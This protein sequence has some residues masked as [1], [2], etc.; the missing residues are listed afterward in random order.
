MPFIQSVQRQ[1]YRMPFIQYVQKQALSTVN[2]YI[3][4]SH[5]FYLSQ[6]PVSR[7]IVFTLQERMFIV[8]SYMSCGN[9]GATGKE[10]ALIDSQLQV[11][12][13]F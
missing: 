2:A 12:C 8:K 4:V 9:Y 3:I 7:R 5:C 6:Q 1:F 10:D 13:G 11:Q